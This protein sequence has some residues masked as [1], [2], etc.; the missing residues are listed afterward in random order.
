MLNQTLPV[1]SVTAAGAALP[2]FAGEVK[3]WNLF[4]PSNPGGC[5]GNGWAVFGATFSP[6]VVS[7]SSTGELELNISGNFTDYDNQGNYT[8]SY[9]FAGTKS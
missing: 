1:A 8:L 3:I 6:S 4:A 7:I 2:G 9:T 5:D